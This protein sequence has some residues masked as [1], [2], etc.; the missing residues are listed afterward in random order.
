MNLEKIKNYLE[1][2]IMIIVAICSIILMCKLIIKKI[3]KN[4][5][6]KIEKDEITDADMQ[7]LK[8][9]LKESISTI[10]TGMMNL[11]GI[12]GKKAYNLLL[13]ETK[14]NKA[15]FEELEQKENEKKGETQ[16]WEE[17]QKELTSQGDEGEQQDADLKSVE[18]EYK[19][20]YPQDIH[21]ISTRYPQKK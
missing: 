14:K 10:A 4:E 18:V 20:S 2:A 13:N 6:G 11:N 17:Q 19:I 1:L 5:N 3:D 9:M 12:T 8:E 15:I 7:F 16:K 21:R